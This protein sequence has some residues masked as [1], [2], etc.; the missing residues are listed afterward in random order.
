MKRLTETDKWKDK[1]FRQL[2]PSYKLIWLYLLDNCDAAGVFDADWSLINFYIGANELD[3]NIILQTFKGRITKIKDDSFIIN[4]FIEYQYPDGI[5]ILCPPHLKALRCLK[6]VGLCNFSVTSVKIGKQDRT[7]YTNIDASAFSTLL[8]TELRIVHGNLHGYPIKEY[9]Y[10]KEEDKEKV[11]EKE[12][13]ELREEKAIAP[14]KQNKRKESPLVVDKIVQ[15]VVEFWNSKNLKKPTIDGKLLLICKSKRNNCGGDVSAVHIFEAISNY[16]EALDGDWYSH[17]YTLKDFLTKESAKR[18]YGDNYT[19]SDYYNKSK[20]E[21]ASESNLN[22][23]QTSSDE[24]DK[25]IWL[26]N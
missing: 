1:W 7:Y 22:L 2:P 11:K 15:D 17:N 19:R 24:E 6:K 18:F 4:K 12:E 9:I 25:C 16:R 26:S 14:K 13:E 10:V 3:E 21:R 20:S 5:K 23:L 8:G